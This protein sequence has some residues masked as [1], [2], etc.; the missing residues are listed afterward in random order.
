MKTQG[1]ASISTREL[2]AAYDQMFAVAERLRDSDSF[3][4]W[5]LDR[6]DPRPGKRLLDVG[7][8][9]G[10]L[11]KY[12]RQRGVQALGVD[13]SAVGAGI[14]LRTAGPGSVA[15]S[16]GERLAFLDESFD[17]AANVG[18]LEHFIHPEAGVREMARVLRPGGRAA[19][20]LPNSYY[21]ADVIWHVWRTGY[22]VS[23]SQPLERFATCGEWREFLEAGGLKV[24]QTY[25]Y[26]FRFPRTRADLAWYRRHPRKALNLL[27]APLTPFNLSYHFLFICRK[28]EPAG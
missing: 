15:L 24:E 26:N 19:L 20:V 3:Y 27:L 16:D 7:C 4:R 23:H 13:L 22:S 17:Y 14:A 6:L 1:N 10:L 18:S 28:G 21:L 2:S 5:V 12:A 9:E 25:K 8:G 11:V